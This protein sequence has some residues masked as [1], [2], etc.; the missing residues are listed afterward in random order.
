M[1]SLDEFV[2]E[3]HL[4][5]QLDEFISWDFIYDIC[6]PL[7]SD[8]GTS[9]VDPVVLFKLMFINIIFGYHSMRR[10]CEANAWGPAHEIGHVHQ[11]AIDWMGSTES[12]LSLIHISSFHAFSCT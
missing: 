4:V 8:I 11:L 10:T 1:G 5:R 9:R 6:D 12:S 3:D 7:Y 2:P